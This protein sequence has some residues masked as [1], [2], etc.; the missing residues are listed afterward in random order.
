MTDLYCAAYR[1]TE[2][3]CALQQ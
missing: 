1:E 2:S 3:C